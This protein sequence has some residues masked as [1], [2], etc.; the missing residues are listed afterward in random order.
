MSSDEAEVAEVVELQDVVKP[1]PQ[2]NARSHL[3]M[4][5]SYVTPIKGL[6]N[7]PSF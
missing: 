2:V 5:T 7:R 1:E 3:P 4:P 6:H